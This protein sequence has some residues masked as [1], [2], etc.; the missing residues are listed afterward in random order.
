MHAEADAE[1][2]GSPLGTNELYG[3]AINLEKVMAAPDSVAGGAKK[4]PL[5]SRWGDAMK[6]LY[7]VLGT[8][9]RI[10][11]LLSCC[12]KAAASAWVVVLID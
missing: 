4:P 11:A 2:G 10:E 3:V 9:H 6:I 12:L 8:S 7:S 1:I 5:A